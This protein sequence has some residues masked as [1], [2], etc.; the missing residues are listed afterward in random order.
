MGVEQVD[1]VLNMIGGRNHNQAA[2]GFQVEESPAGM[3]QNRR[4]GQIKK[5]LGQGR[6]EA[7]ANAPGQNDDPGRR[8]LKSIAGHV[9]VRKKG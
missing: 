3:N 1:G 8:E 4:S 2:N 5:L 7:G 9:C 6:P